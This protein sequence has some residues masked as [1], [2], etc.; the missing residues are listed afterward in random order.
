MSAT[1]QGK[2]MFGPQPTSSRASSPAYG[3][4]S[5]TRNHRAKVF[6]G[7]DFV[8]AAPISITHMG[9]NYETIGAVGTQADSGKPTL[10]QWQF[11]T[12]DRF[13]IT[14]RKRAPGPGAYESDSAFM[15]QTLSGRNSDPFYGF[16]SSDRDNVKKVF[17][18]TAHEKAKHGIQ[19][20]GPAALYHRKGAFGRHGRELGSFEPSPE[21]GFGTDD[22]WQ[23]LS[24]NLSDSAE[25]PGPGSY[26]H[27]STFNTQH[28][29]KRRTDSSYGFGTS[30]RDMQSKVFLSEFHAKSSGG[31]GQVLSPGP[32]SGVGSTS[33]PA[34]GKQNT[35]RGRSASA[36]AFGKMDRFPKGAYAT[37]SPG[38]G[39]YAI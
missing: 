1:I 39:A 17:I 21:F 37:I 25:L 22:R 12:A 20:P 23:R 3:F 7:A 27:D 15:S 30:N 4:G 33:A 35:T 29:S 13:A 34:I 38:P 36:W 26:H 11:G 9:A 28:S 14:A 5:S 16:G 32:A 6:A 19:S 10:P 18:S 8:K 2:S 31:P 24:R